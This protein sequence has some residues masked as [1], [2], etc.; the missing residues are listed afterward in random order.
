MTYT[1]QSL[2]CSFIKNHF[3]PFLNAG[4]QIFYYPATDSP[5]LIL[6]ITEHIRYFYKFECAIDNS[7]NSAFRILNRKEITASR[8]IAPGVLGIFS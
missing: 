2:F 6:A 5:K 7:G 8:A 1:P 3:Q 4:D